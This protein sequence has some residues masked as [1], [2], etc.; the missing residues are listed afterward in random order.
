MCVHIFIYME[1]EIEIDLPMTPISP[2]VLD[3]L[4]Y[5]HLL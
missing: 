4:E 1:R 2:K 5:S 3:L